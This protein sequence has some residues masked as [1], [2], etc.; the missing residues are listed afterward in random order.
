MFA[1][2]RKRHVRTGSTGATTGPTTGATGSASGSHGSHGS[3]GAP[4]PALSICRLEAPEELLKK[5]RRHAD[6]PALAEFTCPICWEPFWQPVRT[7]CGHAFCE[8][9]LLKSVL[10][11]LGHDQPDVSCPLCRHPLHVDDVS[12]DEALLTR[13]RLVIAQKNREIETPGTGR[14]YSG[15]LFRGSTRSPNLETPGMRTLHCTGHPCTP[16]PVE[17]LRAQTSGATRR[18]ILASW[19]RV[20]PAD[21]LRPATSGCGRFQGMN[22]MNELAQASPLFVQS[23]FV[24]RPSTTGAWAQSRH[25]RDDSYIGTVGSVGNVGSGHDGTHSGESGESGALAQGALRP[26]TDDIHAKISKQETQPQQLLQAQPVHGTPV[27]L[28]SKES[29]ESKESRESGESSRT[30]AWDPE[31]IEELD[32]E[33]QEMGHASAPCPDASSLPTPAVSS[34]AHMKPRL[35][36]G[37]VK[38]KRG[39]EKHLGTSLPPPRLA[40]LEMGMDG[41]V[42]APKTA[43]REHRRQKQDLKPPHPK[44]SLASS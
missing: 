38:H 43:R 13:I 14:A 25:R 42:P 21:E 20:A 7:V 28:A 41:I 16:A 12:A 4:L 9:C 24:A 29:K 3:H 27:R 5:L 6:D 35:E 8:G 33:V 18:P 32:C 40:R 23:S 34:Q 30:A 11:Q 2:L 19:M 22:M 26:S 15:R 10:A 1:T 36:Y 17:L 44:R 31:W 39:A 37:A